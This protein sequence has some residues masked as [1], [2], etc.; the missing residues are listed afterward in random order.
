M[1]NYTYV[2]ASIPLEANFDGIW[3]FFAALMLGPTLLLT[4]IGALLLSKGKRKAGKVFMILAGVY[5]LI[6]LGTCGGLILVM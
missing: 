1:L 5:L 4:L 2:I 6:R 3:Y